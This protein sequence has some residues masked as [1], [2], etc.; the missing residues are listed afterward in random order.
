MLSLV[1]LVLVLACALANAVAAPSLS[2]STYK[3][4]GYGWG[5]DMGGLWT[6]T[7]EVSQDVVFVEFYLD[8]QLQLNSTA[9]PFKWQFNT[10]NYN[11][12]EHMIKV[13]AYDSS[14]FT[15]TVEKQANFVEYS[16]TDT[17]F[18]IVAVVIVVF[19]VSL[20]ALLF[21]VRRKTSKK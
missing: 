3:N 13:V 2:I 19:V 18:I 6:F 21:R 5:S 17:L 11:L 9:T 4:N 1:C 16:M 20:A 10:A 7:A 15:G 8:N 12:G 14:G